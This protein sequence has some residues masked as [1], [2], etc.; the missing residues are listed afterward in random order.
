MIDSRNSAQQTADAQGVH[1]QSIIIDMACP[2]IKDRREYLDWYQAGGFTA[3]SVTVA[4]IDDA[5]ETLDRLGQWHRYLRENE[6]TLIKHSAD[7]LAVKRRSQIGVFFHL[8][9][10][11]PIEDDLG[12]VDL[13][14][15]LG[16]GVVQLTY[17]VRNRVGFGCEELVDD[18]L[19]VFGSQLVDKLNSAR[20]IVD[21]S[22]TG[23]HTSLDAIERSKQPVILSH[24]NSHEVYNSTRNVPFGLLKAI[25]DS[26]GVIGVAGFPAMVSSKSKPEL[27]D[28]V[29]HIDYLV[30]RLGID[31]VG[32]GIDY[33]IGQAGV[34]HDEE[35]L[36]TYREKVQSGAWG[37][38]YPP[39]PHH[40]PIGIET[41]KTLYRLTDHLLARGYA[42]ADV[43]K[44]LGR[45]WLRVFQEVWG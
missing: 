8:Q 38:A 12:L 11:D 26:R 28:F 32:L 23:L 15:A 35:A 17:N 25:S 22:H 4:T 44:I 2:L 7:V 31:F 43:E 16:V 5:R 3:A 34:A 21:C 30:Q 39:P 33:Y 36:R 9:G 37:K 14:K 24:S 42:D 19:S 20:V 13:Y 6:V 18:G 10:A 45:N 41:P 1:D 27:E 40:Y 29:A